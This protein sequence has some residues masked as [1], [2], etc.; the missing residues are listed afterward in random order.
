M[1]LE[2]VETGLVGGGVVGKREGLARRLQRVTVEPELLENGRQCVAGE[3]GVRMVLAN[4]TR[5]QLGTYAVPSKKMAD[6]D[7]APRLDGAVTTVLLLGCAK[8]LACT[9]TA[10]DGLNE[11]AGLLT[12]KVPESTKRVVGLALEPALLGEAHR[13]MVAS[14]RLAL[15]PRRPAH[16]LGKRSASLVVVAKRLVL[17]GAIEV[18]R[19]NREGVNLAPEKH[20]A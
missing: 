6:G 1:N 16:G 15:V 10:F 4:V 12:I 2:A 8:D 17:I 13:T 19:G 11:V 9:G 20:R 3:T 18:R 5:S 14:G 7:L